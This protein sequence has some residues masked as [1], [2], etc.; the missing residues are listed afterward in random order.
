MY[1]R[2]ATEVNSRNNSYKFPKKQSHFLAIM[3]LRS[4]DFWFY[5]AFFIKNKT[6]L[7]LCNKVISS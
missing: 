1:A 3:T 4:F 6:F 5:Q 2:Y 7:F